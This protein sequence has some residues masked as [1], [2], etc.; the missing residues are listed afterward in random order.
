MIGDMAASIVI[1]INIIR[2]ANQGSAVR[3]GP[4]V[5]III[6]SS[7]IITLTVTTIIIIIIII[8]FIVLVTSGKGL[9]QRAGC[10]GP[11][12]E[13]RAE[14]KLPDASGGQWI[15]A[16]RGAT[17]KECPSGLSLYSE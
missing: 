1:A 6:L 9:A 8:I 3:R 11:C 2:D 10:R 7:S 4:R 13:L 12:F 17:D 14:A 5:V 15:R 16:R